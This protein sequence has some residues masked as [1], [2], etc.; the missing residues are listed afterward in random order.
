MFIVRVKPTLRSNRRGEWKSKELEKISKTNNQRELGGWKKLRILIAE[1][2]AFRLLFLSFTNH[3][4]YSIKNICIYS[5]S[6]IKTKVTNKHNFSQSFSFSYL[7][8]T[9]PYAKLYYVAKLFFLPP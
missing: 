4:N 8:V 5:K 3:E 7:E 2:L 6:K 1:G 9:L